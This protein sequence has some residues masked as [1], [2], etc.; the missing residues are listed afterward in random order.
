MSR[1]ARL[2]DVMPEGHN[3]LVTD[4]VNVRYLCGFTGSHGAVLVSDSAAYL[5]TDT[6]YTIQA[7]SETRDVEVVTVPDLLAGATALSRGAPL[8]IEAL[9]MSVADD[10]R[11]GS[12][13][14]TSGLVEGLRA[15]KDAQEVAAIAEACDVA[16]EALS[17]T[18]PR[19]QLGL[20]ERA[21]ATALERTMVDLGAE[22]RAFESIVAFGENSAVPHHS[23]TDRELR[24]GDLIKI[25]FGAK[26]AGYHSDCTRVFS[27]GVA[28]DW[29]RDIHAVVAASQLAGREA[30]HAGATTSSVY[31]NARTPMHG[32]DG[33]FGHG[34]GH[35]V[36]LRIHEDPFF[37]L[38]GD[39]RLSD[40]SVV[41]VEPGIYLAGRG[42]VRIEDTLVVTAGG[43]EVLTNLPRE[44]INVL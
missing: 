37:R 23:P 30:L 43:S 28:A 27:A 8:A 21:L 6:R 20:S 33:A 14:R 29:Q 38:S 13:T 40:G 19:V 11:L 32:R 12:P 35:G 7:A 25:D 2:R 1:I 4:L 22:D 42:G 39:G 26:V 31:S 10:L 24:R 18:L 44:L 5:L 16:C 34:L 15:V 9:A 3:L 36:G 41:T 17:A